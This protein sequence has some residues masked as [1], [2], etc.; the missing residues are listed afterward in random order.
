MRIQGEEIEKGEKNI[1]LIVVRNFPQLM[2]D[3]KPQIQKA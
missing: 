1:E 3:T 2:I